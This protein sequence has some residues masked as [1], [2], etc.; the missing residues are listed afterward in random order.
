MERRL[1]RGLDSLIPRGP[2]PAGRQVLD[3]AVEAI[4]PNPD[5]PRKVFNEA[6]LEALAASIRQHGVVQPIIVQATSGGY[7]LVA[8]ERR[9]RASRLAGKPTIPA[10]VVEPTT[11]SRSLEVAL[12][13]NLQREN[14]GPLEEAAAYEALLARGNLTHQEAADR[15]GRSRVAV[16]N[17]LRLLELPET[18]K[19]LLNSGAL[20][21]GQGRAILAAATDLDRERLAIEAVRNAWTVRSIE[22]RARTLSSPERRGGGRRRA[23]NL[24]NASHYAEQL[25]ILYGT[26][27]HIREK[28]GRGELAFE[29][30]S[31]AD[32]D[33]LLHRLLTAAAAS[34]ELEAELNPAPSRAR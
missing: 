34:E 1:G 14:L 32:R 23:A 18:V 17:S 8:G 21:A 27:V 11:G 22:A 2:A 3:V 13:E 30:Y 16:T 31:A 28:G 24:K 6:H 33:R 19:R 7:Q 4:S 15:L 10:L 25:Q 26:R 9:L 12:I 5:Q 20:S 29:F